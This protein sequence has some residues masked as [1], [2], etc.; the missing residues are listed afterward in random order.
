VW[1]IEINSHVIIVA[2][3]GHCWV[4]VVVVAWLIVVIKEFY[5]LLNVSLSDWQSH[6]KSSNLS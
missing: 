6:A 1:L 2:V 4:F 3:S 5:D